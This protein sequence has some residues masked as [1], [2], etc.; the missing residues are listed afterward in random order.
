MHIYH[1][2]VLLADSTMD[3]DKYLMELSPTFNDFLRTVNSSAPSLFKALEKVPLHPGKVNKNIQNSHFLRIAAFCW[4]KCK[5]L[6]PTF[7]ISWLNLLFLILS[8]FV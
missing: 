8:I 6:G 2:D 5:W 4:E 1:T 7:L 3:L